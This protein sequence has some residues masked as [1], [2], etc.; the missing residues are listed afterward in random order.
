M[1]AFGQVADALTAITH[2]AEL[3]AAQQQAFDT[4]HT[5]L[6]LARKS[7]QAGET[8]LL[9]VQDAERQLAQAQLGLIRAQSQRYQDTAAL[10][11]ALGGSPVPRE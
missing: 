1:H 8:N 9:L 10:F 5:S 11:V 6:T 7:Y 4:A 3:N 2:D